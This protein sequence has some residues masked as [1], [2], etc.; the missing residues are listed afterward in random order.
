MNDIDFIK[1]C[2]EYADGFAFYKGNVTEN[3]PEIHFYCGYK[4]WIQKHG[5]IGLEDSLHYPLLLQR[6]I[7]GVNRGDGYLIFQSF[8]E[9][10]IEHNENHSFEEYYLFENYSSVDQ[11]KRKALECVFEQERDK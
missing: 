3:R 8:S 7:E 5:M 11:A 10:R 2:C 1:K 6:A 4:D 9:I